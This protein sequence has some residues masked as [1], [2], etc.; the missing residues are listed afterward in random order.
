MLRRIDF[1]S[2]MGD[3]GYRVNGVFDETVFTFLSQNLYFF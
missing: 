3:D 2:I 1:L